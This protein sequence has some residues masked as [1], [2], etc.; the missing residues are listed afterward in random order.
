MNPEAIR[1]K[2]VKGSQ[3]DKK[4][5]YELALLNKIANASY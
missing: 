2:F 3:Y 5:S 1:K 4:K